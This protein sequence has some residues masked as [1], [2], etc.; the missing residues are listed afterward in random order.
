MCSGLIFGL[1]TGSNL[2]VVIV[3]ATVAYFLVKEGHSPLALTGNNIIIVIFLRYL[4]VF[5]ICICIGKI[6]NGIPNFRSP[7]SDHE[8]NDEK[9]TF[10]EAVQNLWPG[11]IIVP[12]VSILST[13][14]IAKAFSE[15]NLNSYLSIGKLYNNFN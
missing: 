8:D 12:L 1:T 10:F 7:F 11:I 6:V 3:S 15:C 4:N 2:L 5:T 14:S 9:F 13:I